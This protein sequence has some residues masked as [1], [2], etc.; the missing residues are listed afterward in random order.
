[1]RGRHCDDI[2]CAGR[3][4]GHA[5]VALNRAHHRAAHRV[6]DERAWWKAVGIDPVKIARK[7]WKQTR[8]EEGQMPP[9]PPMQD[10]KG[11]RG[12]QIRK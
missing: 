12:F 4:L 3:C 10:A 7:L 9:D 2:S 8:I 5:A 6:G 1:M 11:E